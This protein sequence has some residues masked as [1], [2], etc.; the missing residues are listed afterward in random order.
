MAKNKQQPKPKKQV[1]P[2]PPVATPVRMNYF[3][4]GIILFTTLFI[5]WP[6]LE[7]ELTNWDDKNYIT[8]NTDLADASI[9]KHFVEKPHVMGNYHPLSMLTLAWN[10]QSAF[11]PTTGKIDPVPFHRTNL[12]IHVLNALL[13]Y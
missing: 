9:H 1:A 10:Y 4:L 6:S 12:I 3:L 8:I 7:N 5:Y 11:D 13:V 2:P